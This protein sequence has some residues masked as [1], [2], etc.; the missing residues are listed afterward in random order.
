MVS[1]KKSNTD[2]TGY[3]P[4]ALSYWVSGLYLLSRI[5]N[6]NVS[7]TVSVSIHRNGR[8]TLCCVPYKGLTSINELRSLAFLKKVYTRR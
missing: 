6:T 8:E 4:R 5:V 2:P 7:E 3:K 1:A